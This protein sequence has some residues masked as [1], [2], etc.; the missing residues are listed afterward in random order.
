MA[1]LSKSS[2]SPNPIHPTPPVYVRGG[3]T[4]DGTEGEREVMSKEKE[5]ERGITWHN[6]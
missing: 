2:L 5:E 3:G 6:D 4:I 1:P